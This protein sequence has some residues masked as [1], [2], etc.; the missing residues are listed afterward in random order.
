M[1]EH[2]DFILWMCLFPLSVVLFDYI[3]VKTMLKQGIENPVCLNGD[4]YA[5]IFLFY[6]FI[7]LI[8]W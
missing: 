3:G 8:I 7:A 4:S 6:L 5:R 2:L 1:V